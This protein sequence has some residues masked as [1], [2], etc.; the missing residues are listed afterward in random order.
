MIKTSNNIYLVYDQ[1]PSSNLRQHLAKNP[2]NRKQSN[3]IPYSELEIM[4][5]IAKTL[6]TL[7]SKNIILLALSWENIYPREKNEIFF[8][9]WSIARLSES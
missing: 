5:S 1:F 9:D 8:G 4:E 3:I 2:P 6:Q 7:H